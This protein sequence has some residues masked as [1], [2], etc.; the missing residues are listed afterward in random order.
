MMACFMLELNTIDLKCPI[1]VQEIFIL[2]GQVKLP[3]FYLKIYLASYFSQGQ[4][5]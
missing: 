1:V 2:E 4:I 5:L 3:S